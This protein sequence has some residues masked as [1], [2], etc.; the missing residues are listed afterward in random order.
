M[1]ISN[2]SCKRRK[3]IKSIYLFSVSIGGDANEM[4]GTGFAA[5][6]C[7]RFGLEI[8]ARQCEHVNFCTLGV[9]SKRV[10]SSRFSSNV[11]RCTSVSAVSQIMSLIASFESIRSKCC[12]MLKNGISCGVSATL[13]HLQNIIN[14]HGELKYPHYSALTCPNI[15]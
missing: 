2:G 12:R 15:V 4:I 5:I 1:F 7:L 8:S 9:R 13:K 11:A 6:D 10:E 3:D 14:I